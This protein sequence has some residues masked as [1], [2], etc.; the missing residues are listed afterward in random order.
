MIEGQ[1]YLDN[2][3]PSIDYY[4]FI[5]QAWPQQTIEVRMDKEDFAVFF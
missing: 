2:D 3:T 4:N 1:Q 5:D